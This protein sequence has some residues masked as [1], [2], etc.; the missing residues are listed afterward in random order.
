MC[1]PEIVIV[2]DRKFAMHRSISITAAAA[3][4]L[5][6]ASGVDAPSEPG[7]TCGGDRDPDNE[8]F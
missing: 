5:F 4:C 7:E 2:E 3:W 6:S 1:E 8:T